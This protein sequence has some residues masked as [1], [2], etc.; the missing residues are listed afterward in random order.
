MHTTN[1]EIN[2]FTEDIQK[3]LNSLSSYEEL[4]K[5][6]K[7]MNKIF[8]EMTLV[9]S[10]L[11]A[12]EGIPLRIM[13]DCLDNTEEITNE[14][15]NIAYDG[16]IFIDKFNISP[17]EFGI[18]WYNKGVLIEDV[19]FASQGELSF[20]S[21]ALSFALSSRVLSKYNIMLLDE[22]DGPLDSTNREKFIRILENQIE[23]INSEQNFLI[24]HNSMFSSYPVDI[25]DL[26][27]K[28]DKDQ[29]PLANFITFK[30]L[31]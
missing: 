6:L 11:S 9:K 13:R 19:K 10:S 31:S 21:L 7:K 22:I 29:Y 3:R 12:K 14:L 1:S 20:L 28:N 5:E 2:A 25:I 27:G 23:R 30:K 26:S 15:L 4:N 18:P 24:T 16:N 8:D 17:T